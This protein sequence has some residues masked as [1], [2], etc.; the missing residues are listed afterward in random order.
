MSGEPRC[1]LDPDCTFPPHEPSD[2]PCG[3]RCVPGEP[4]QYCGKATPLNGD[5][6]PDCWTPLSVADFRAMMAAEGFDTVVT[7]PS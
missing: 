6:C 2:H 1:H 7:P 5:P 4:C 3:R